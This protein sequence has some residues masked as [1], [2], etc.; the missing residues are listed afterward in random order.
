MPERIGSGWMVLTGTRGS[1]GQGKGRPGRAAGDYESLTIA[2]PVITAE[3][4]K[5][6]VDLPPGRQG[7]AARREMNKR[8]IRRLIEHG[9]SHQAGPVLLTL[10][11][12]SLLTGLPLERVGV[13]FQ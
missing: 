5:A 2:W 7:T 12:L 8:R 4:I 1:K 13:Y 9:L 10:T 6:L 3:D 11:D